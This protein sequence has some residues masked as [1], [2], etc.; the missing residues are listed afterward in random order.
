LKKDF[1]EDFRLFLEMYRSQEN[2]SYT[3]FSDGEL[4]VMQNKRLILGQNKVVVGDEVLNFGYNPEDHK[5]F[6]PRLHGFFSQKLMESYQHSQENY[7]V[8]LSCPC[9]VSEEDNKWMIENHKN[10]KRFLTWSNLFV[11]SNYPLFLKFFIPEFKKRKIVMVCNRDADLSGLPFDVVKDFRIGPNALIND[12]DL[13]GE[14]LR[15]IQDEKIKNHTFL[16]CASSLSNII[17]HRC[18]DG[19]NTFLDVGSTLNKFLKMDIARGYLKQFWIAKQRNPEFFKTCVW[20]L[21]EK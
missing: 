15:W 14:I 1:K 13:S 9:C 16:L 8:G 21:E 17:A 2:F 18:F 19:Q 6:N 5:D 10:D 3:R 4:F 20:T 11:N 7:F 12:Y